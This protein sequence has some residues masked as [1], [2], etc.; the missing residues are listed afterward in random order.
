MHYLNLFEAQEYPRDYI[1]KTR[2]I[3]YLL[4]F[5]ICICMI[6]V[7]PGWVCFIR[8]DFPIGVF[9]GIQ[10]FGLIFYILTISS[11]IK[12]FHKDSWLVNLQ[13]GNMLIKIRS[14][15]NSKLPKEDKQIVDLSYNEID[16]IN[17]LII[18]RY[19]YSKKN[20]Q[21]ISKIR[22]LEI[23]LKTGENNELASFLKEERGRRIKTKNGSS[24]SYHYPVMLTGGQALRVEWNNVSP[25]IDRVIS[26]LAELGI[27]IA[28]AENRTE[29]YTISLKDKKQAEDKVLELLERGESMAASKLL[30]RN[31]GMTLKEARQF[32]KDLS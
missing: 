27:K 5:L 20:G 32:I 25:S 7:L 13:P 16:Y 31:F 6:G 14:F 11:F 28:D 24:I 21:K 22:F 30:R 26:K 2:W 15:H 10:V 23:H 9:I 3:T 8:K 19:T 29:D 1:Y 12:A 18:T 17:K 4:G